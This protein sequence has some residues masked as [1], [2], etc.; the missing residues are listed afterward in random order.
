[1]SFFYHSLSFFYHL[2][3]KRSTS[4]SMSR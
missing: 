4:R 2:T 3:R 1:M